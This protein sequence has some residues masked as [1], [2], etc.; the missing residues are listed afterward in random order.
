[1]DA[2]VH[3]VG[4]F[5]ERR[6]TMDEV[7]ARA[8]V[9]RATAFRRF[10]TRDE[11][12]RRTYMREIRRTLAAVRDA[13]DGADD[14]LAVGFATLAEIVCRHPITTRMART[15]PDLA[16]EMWRSGSPSGFT[17]V[18]TVIEGLAEPA[19]RDQ[20]DLLTRLLLSY[21]LLPEVAP[22]RAQIERQ[23]RRKARA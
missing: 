1:M 23:V 19:D 6:L 15:E 13:I 10:G 16:I 5:G 4:E 9:A 12:L 11:L 7:A 18:R 8:R 21:L 17:V 22:T 14:R 20:A 3:L 2:A